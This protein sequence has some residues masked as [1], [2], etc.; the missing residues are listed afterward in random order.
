MVFCPN[1]GSVMDEADANYLCPECGTQGYDEYGP[2]GYTMIFK[3]CSEDWED[4]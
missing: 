3:P 2:D 1:C 4:E